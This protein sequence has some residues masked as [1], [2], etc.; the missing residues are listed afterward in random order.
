[1]VAW[2]FVDIVPLSWPAVPEDQSVCLRWVSEQG[3]LFVDQTQSKPV[4]SSL[5]GHRAQLRRDGEGFKV[6]VFHKDLQ[7][8]D[9]RSQKILAIWG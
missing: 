8:P 1:M 5:G 2:V 7:R 3:G 4:V 9:F 6:T